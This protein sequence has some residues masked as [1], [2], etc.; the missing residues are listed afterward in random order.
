MTTK[1]LRVT[2]AE[3]LRLAAPTL[4]EL[5]NEMGVSYDMARQFAGRHKTPS[6]EVARALVR[7]L[8]RRAKRL[9]AAAVLLTTAARKAREGP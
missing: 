7:V 2:V 6:P 8:R 5:A 4:R 9:N 3:A 1:G